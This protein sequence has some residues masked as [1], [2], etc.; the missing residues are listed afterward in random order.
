M[1]IEN[2]VFP[3][4]GTANEL[5][6]TSLPFDLEKAVSTTVLYELLE[7]Q[8]ATEETP[9]STKQVT[10]GN[11]TLTPEEYAAWG[12]DNTHVIQCVAN[13]LGVTLITE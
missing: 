11:Y 5:R 4:L 10:N 2:V 13:Y 12:E 1:K 6:V 3:I 7:V 9:Q 8:S